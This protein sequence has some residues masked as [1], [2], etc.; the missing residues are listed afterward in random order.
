[1]FIETYLVPSLPEPIRISDYA[2]QVLESISTK[3]SL[4]KALSKKLVYVNGTLVNSSY[5]LKQGDRIEIKENEVRRKV[6]ELQL[7]VLLEEEEFAV[8]HKPAGIEVSGNKFKTIENALPFNLTLSR[9]KD[10]LSQPQAIHRLDYPTS[11]LLVIGKTKRAVQVLNKQFEEKKVNKIYHAITIGKMPPKEDVT[12]SVDGKDSKSTFKVLETISSER[13]QFL[14]L[15]ELS[16]ITGRRHQL[17]VHMASLNT[18]IL[19]DQEYGIENKIL[20]G[21]GLYL[22]A[23]EITFLHPTMKEKIELKIPLANKFTKIFTN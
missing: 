17:R 6:Y 21:K 15:V 20:K 13:F 12:T 4:K 9:C 2:F 19:G 22:Q 11:G 5:V 23:S 10:A 16:P 1:M 18:P 7:E 8:I 3:S 14:N